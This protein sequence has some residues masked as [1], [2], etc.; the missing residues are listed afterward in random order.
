MTT[1]E[2][3]AK[4]RK[5]KGLTQEQLAQ[6][7]GVTR[8]A[9]S[10]WEGDIAFPETD[11]L[12]KMCRLFGVSCD[13][14]LNYDGEPPQAAQEEKSG[15]FTFDLKSL[16][17]EY[18]SKAHWGKLPLVHINIGIGRV[19]KGVF[20]LG[21][22]SVGLVSVGVVSLGLIAFGSVC[23]ALLAFGALSAGLIAFGGAAFGIIALGG[24]AIGLFSMGGGAI[25]LF[26]CGGYAS[27][28][29]VAV[30]DVAV[31]GIAF[32]DT[33]AR[34]SVLSVLIPEYESMKE[35]IADKFEEIPKIWSVFASWSRSLAESF[36]KT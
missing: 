3:I 23:L 34:G 27:G 25:G 11:N 12:T 10:R 28:T 14:L 24:L 4:C 36:M 13:W 19:A 2:K 17:F 33:S 26:A 35:V 7:M 31:G 21:L 1:G 9:V 20:S 22:V 5:E 8:Q 30:G 6:A 29:F 18:K 16:H 15:V 32:G